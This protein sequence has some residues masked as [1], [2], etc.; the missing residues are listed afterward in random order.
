[1]DYVQSVLLSRV[2]QRGLAVDVF[3]LQTH[4][5]VQEQVQTLFLAFPADVEQD[6]LL[7]AVLEV[8]VGSEADKQFHDVVR[9]FVVDEDGGEIEGWLPG[10]RFEPIDDNG[11]VFVEQAFDLFDGAASRSRSTNI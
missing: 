5:L 6:G 8:G 4:P 3:V 7:I 11:V 9:Y 2:E 1:M 10:L